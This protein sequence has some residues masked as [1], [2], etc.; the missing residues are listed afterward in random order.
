MRYG[1][2]LIFALLWAYAT[3]AQN[4]QNGKERFDSYLK[5]KGLDSVFTLHETEFTEAQS[6]L[7]LKFS[8]P[9]N[10]REQNNSALALLK[11][12]YTSQGANLYTVLYSAFVNAYSVSEP[13]N[14]V[15]VIRHEYVNTKPDCPAIFYYY[16]DATKQFETNETLCKADIDKT[17][18]FPKFKYWEE[19]YILENPQKSKH[20]Y[21]TILKG[22]FNRLYSNR[23]GFSERNKKAKFS[24]DYEDGD[25]FLEFEV[26]GLH[27]EVLAGA[28]DNFVK[29][30]MFVFYG[31]E[32]LPPEKIR[33]K[34]SLDFDQTSKQ[35]DIKVEV[36]GRYASCVYSGIPQ[37][38]KMNDM[39]TGFPLYIEDYAKKVF[40]HVRTTILK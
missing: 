18:K 14:A 30:L 3:F 16:D 9:N 35:A 20:L 39:D 34:I 11:Q 17:V 21:Y 5:S 25:K 19:S 1:F 38:E 37:W 24:C 40:N 2:T 27:D 36:R 6:V 23:G 7:R 13:R 33:V 8:N 22:E 31:E 32:C 26:S 10:T 4:A 29:Q 12:E 28:N 15:L